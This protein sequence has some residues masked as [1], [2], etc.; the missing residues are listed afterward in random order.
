MERS[1]RSVR[2]YEP[3]TALLGGADGLDFYRRI[4]PAARERL[5]P[6]GWLLLEVGYTQADAVRE[7]FEKCGYIDIEKHKDFGGHERVVEGRRET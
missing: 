5:C 3:K 2:D 7:I 1:R 6:G 4:I